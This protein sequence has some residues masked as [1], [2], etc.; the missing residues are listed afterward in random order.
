MSD[1]SS[2][3]TSLDYEDDYLDQDSKQSSIYQEDEEGIEEYSYTWQDVEG[4]VEIDEGEVMSNT[5][6]NC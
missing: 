3:G 4:G 5:A 2:I 1:R 6:L